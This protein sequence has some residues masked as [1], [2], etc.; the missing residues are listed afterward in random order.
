MTITDRV[1]ELVAGCRLLDHPFYT[2]WSEGRL[3]RQA[4]AHYAEQYYAW[5]SAFPTFLSATHAN[6]SDLDMRRRILENLIDEEHGAENHPDLWLRFCDAL[7]LDRQ[8][9]TRMALLPETGE[10]IAAFRR[11]CRDGSPV[12]ALAVLYAYESQQPT[13]MATKR[14]GLSERYGVRTG[15]DYFV[16]HESLDIEH[17]RV[18]RELVERHSSGHEDEILQAVEAGLAATYR[19]LDGIN[20]R[21]VAY[22]W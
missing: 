12:A 17:S 14:A 10:A 7:G 19:L 6:C 4:L 16:A 21:Y 3:T 13:V 18:E 2:A 8:A 1:D 20:N 11:L 15:H 9:V 22:S 5:V